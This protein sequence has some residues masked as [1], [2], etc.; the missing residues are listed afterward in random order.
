MYHYTRDRAML[1]KA[2]LRR[3]CAARAA[4]MLPATGLLDPAY[5]SYHAATMAAQEAAGR[6][7]SYPLAFPS[8]LAA[9]AASAAGAA[10]TAL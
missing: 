9:E 6:R 2:M 10:I 3:G 5:Q 7:R 8:D 1:T 4:A